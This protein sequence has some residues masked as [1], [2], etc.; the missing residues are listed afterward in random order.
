VPNFE[1]RSGEDGV[2]EIW[3]G[4][5]LIGQIEPTPHGLRLVVGDA[6]APHG[7]TLQWGG[8][9]FTMQFALTAEVI[10]MPAPASG[11][12]P[13]LN[14][15]GRCRLCNG[16]GAVDGEFCSCR[17]GRDLKRL[18]NRGFNNPSEL[19]SIDV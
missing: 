9:P 15:W 18:N 2:V 13:D 6:H 14:A 11:A 4:A 16:T 1:L 8:E 7:P 10:Q 17:M 12:S 19:P 5:E 3:R